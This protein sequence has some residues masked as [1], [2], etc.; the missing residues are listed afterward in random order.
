MGIPRDS[1]AFDIVAVMIAV[2]I[3]GLLAAMAI[4]AYLKVRDETIYKA[5]LRG[6]VLN[7]KERVIFDRVAREH[8]KETGTPAPALVAPEP[9]RVALRTFQT[10]VVGDRTYYL[11]PKQ[12]YPQEIVVDG[13]NFWLVPTDGR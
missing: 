5:G 4:P 13:R 9:A 2:V 12:A 10:I 3:V 11:V 7:D 8:T 6:E 1:R